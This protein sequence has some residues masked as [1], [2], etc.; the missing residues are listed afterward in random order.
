MCIRKGEE[1]REGER[2]EEGIDFTAPRVT[3][4]IPTECLLYTKHPC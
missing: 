2:K 3:H 1:W 4:L